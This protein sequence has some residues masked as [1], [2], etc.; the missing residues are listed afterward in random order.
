MGKAK[1]EIIKI[2]DYMPIEVDDEK[3]KLAKSFVKNE[4]LIRF[5]KSINYNFKNIYAQGKILLN[6]SKNNF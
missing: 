5:D 3:V 6:K 2:A 4:S 1:N